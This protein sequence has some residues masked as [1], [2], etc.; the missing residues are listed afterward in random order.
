MPAAPFLALITP[1]A[2]PEQPPQPPLGIWGPSDPRPTLPIAG[3]DPGTGT[4]PKP[5]PP[6]PPLVIWGPG[7]PRPTLPIAGWDPG[8]GAFPKPP[9]PPLGTWGGAGQPF[10]TNPIAEPPW[11][12]GNKPPEITLP[13]ET[14]IGPVDWKCAWT[15]A[16]GWVVIGIPTGPVPTPSKA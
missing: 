12:W 8:S 10:P 9:Q 3:W 6:Q 5:Q 7:D 11:G 15:P 16:T 13:P 1:L 14:P 2:A 4:F